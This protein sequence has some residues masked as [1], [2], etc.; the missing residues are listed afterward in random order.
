LAT[1]IARAFDLR[2]GGRRSAADALVAFLRDRQLL[3]LLDNFEH[4]TA[5]A[6]LLADLL[7]V[8]GGLTLLVTSRSPVRLRGEQVLPVPPLPL[9][10]P[11]RAAPFDRLRHVPSVALFAQRAHA[12][13][14][15]FALTT[16]NVAAV[17]EICRR[18]DGLPLAIELAAARTPLLPPSALLSR[19]TEAPA[20][21]L[22]TDGARDLPERQQ[23]L[24][25]TLEWSHDLLNA[26]EQRLFRRLSIFAGGATLDA[27]GA[28]SRG[29]Q[30]APEESSSREED[31]SLL[32]PST[33]RLLD[34]LGSLVDKSLVHLSTLSTQHSALST[35]YGMLETV[36]EF[37]RELLAASGE[38]PD[39]ERAHARYFLTLAET[40]VSELTGADQAAWLAR[41]DAEHE[42]LR[43]VLGRALASGDAETGL[44]LAVSIWRFWHSRGYLTEGRRWLDELLA[45]PAT[46]SP[47]T[48][49]GG[50]GAAGLFA[51]AVGNLAEAEALLEESLA[52]SRELGDDRRIANLLGNLGV[53]AQDRGDLDRAAVLLEECLAVDRALGDRWGLAASLTNLARLARLR[54]DLPRSRALQAESLALIRELG[55]ARGEAMSLSNLASI[56]KDEGDLA[57]AE[58][59]FEESLGRWRELGELRGIGVELR[60]LGMVAADRGDSAR[61]EALIVESVSR[62]HAID[63]VQDTLIG[64]EMLAPVAVSQGR[65]RRAVRLLAAADALRESLDV[66]RS[67]DEPTAHEDAVVAVR[68]ALPAD[69]FA[70]AWAEGA[71]LSLDEAVAI[72]RTEDCAQRAPLRAE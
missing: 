23:T 61:A 19:L 38:E 54:G 1:T 22:L 20:L 16:E 28:V 4:L 34:S 58:A 24:R 26:D 27:A 40:A 32:D 42:N 47:A 21:P 48:R 49:A 17:A 43:A 33:A 70:T 8:C 57:T 13:D 64:L 37:G 39:T 2:E 3:L 36:R 66:P 35:R 44:R 10:E 18:L 29:A 46:T 71:A 45:L 53:I 65:P 30:R 11:F 63:A 56:A 14:P 68:A 51:Y 50:L 7:A 67:P 55:D 25:R 62:L 59:L 72:T 52:L 12:A 69:G 6:T 60:H 15:D 5:G 41:L 31:H 9:P